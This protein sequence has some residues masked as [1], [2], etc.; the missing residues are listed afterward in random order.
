MN[1]KPRRLVGEHFRGDGK[2]KRRFDT[3]AGAEAFIALYGYLHLKI[4]G[5]CE[6][7][8]GY[9]LGTRRLSG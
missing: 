2:P 9:H 8:G 5:P 1:Y 3:H 7:C 6:F 4:Y